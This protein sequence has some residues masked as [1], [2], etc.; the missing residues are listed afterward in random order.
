MTAEFRRHLS[1]RSRNSLFSTKMNASWLVYDSIRVTL[2]HRIFNL[3]N[4][5]E[6][7]NGTFREVQ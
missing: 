7:G 6:I 5:P 3:H 4:K 1:A 2:N